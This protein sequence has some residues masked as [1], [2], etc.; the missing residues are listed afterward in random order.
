M[1]KF[2]NY[3]LFKGLTPLEKL[4]L[5]ITTF[6]TSGCLRPAPGTWGS[7]AASLVSWW[8]ATT[9]YPRTG[10]WNN[11]FYWAVACFILGWLCSIVLVKKYR[12]LG[13]K[14]KGQ[15]N[16]PSHIVIDEAAAIFLVNF[17]LYT[18]VNGSPI[19]YDLSWLV[20]LI[21][22]VVFRFFDITKL[23]LIGVVDRKV[24]GAFG[25]M[26]DDIVAAL[27]SIVVGVLI[28]MVLVFTGWDKE[29]H[30]YLGYAR[31]YTRV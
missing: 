11:Q 13:D 4:C 14:F 19:W 23:S 30:Q 22:F 12:S 9:A 24:K 21:G 25:L 18:Y 3:Q 16:D 29:L 7:L 5:F 8:L 27:P 1:L 2:Y 20:A 6:G 31:T 15:A 17:V 28:L 26:L 10:V